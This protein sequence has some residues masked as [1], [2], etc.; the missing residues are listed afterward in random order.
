MSHSDNYSTKQH[1]GVPQLREA[2]GV[3]LAMQQVP[4]EEWVTEWVKIGD[5]IER[6]GLAG[7]RPDHDEFDYFAPSERNFFIMAELILFHPLAAETLVWC[8]QSGEYWRGIEWIFCDCYVTQAGWGTDIIP[9]KLG[10]ELLTLDFGFMR[11]DQ[12]SDQQLAAKMEFD[13]V[14]FLKDQVAAVGDELKRRSP[15]RYAEV[16]DLLKR[17]EVHRLPSWSFSINS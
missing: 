15:E 6:A 17:I 10:R 2:I 16:M 11:L 1:Y 8:A 3:R 14:Y 5:Q 4:T 9:L 13:H 12:M 7:D